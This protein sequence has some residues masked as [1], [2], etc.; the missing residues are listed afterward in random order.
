MNSEVGE[1]CAI[2][3]DGLDRPEATAAGTLIR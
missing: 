1:G 2:E 3:E